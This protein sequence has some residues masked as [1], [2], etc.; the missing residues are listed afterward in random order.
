M[1]FD[2]D[3]LLTALLLNGRVATEEV[4]DHRKLW[5]LHC[6]VAKPDLARHT[7]E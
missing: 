4:R 7:T 3:V 6:H 2:T 1:R 5:L